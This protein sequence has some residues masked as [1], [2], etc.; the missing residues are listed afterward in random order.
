MQKATNAPTVGQRT[1]DSKTD[2]AA[3]G[4]ANTKEFFNH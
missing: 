3:S 4:A 1:E 2:P